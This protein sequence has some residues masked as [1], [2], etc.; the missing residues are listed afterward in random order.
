M[1]SHSE[2]AR[3]RGDQRSAQMSTSMCATGGPGEAEGEQAGG[4]QPHQRDDRLVAPAP[5]VLGK[6]LALRQ[7]LAHRRDGARRPR[8]L[9]SPRQSLEC[10]VALRHCQLDRQI[11]GKLHSVAGAPGLPFGGQARAAARVPAVGAR[12][13]GLGERPAGV[14]ERRIYV[15]IG[16]AER[17][18]LEHLPAARHS[19]VRRA[20]DAMWGRYLSRAARA[21]ADAPRAAATRR[22][23]RRSSAR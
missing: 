10:G 17:P 2:A 22:R 20:G 5:D 19:A 3:Y 8:G 18:R 6:H 15:E 1:R 7:P 21:A 16:G 23:A 11:T 13:L 12:R 14:G 9:N 4:V